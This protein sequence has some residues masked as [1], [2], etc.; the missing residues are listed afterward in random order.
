MIS[1]L[2]ILIAFLFLSDRI[3]EGIAAGLVKG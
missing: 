2:P 3:I 1:V